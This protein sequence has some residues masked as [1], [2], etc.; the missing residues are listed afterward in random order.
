M[1]DYDLE[2]SRFL[3]VLLLS[4]VFLETIATFTLPDI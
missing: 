4:G 1:E 3:G 2:E